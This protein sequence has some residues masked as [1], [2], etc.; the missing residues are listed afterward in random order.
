MKRSNGNPALKISR[1]LIQIL[2]F[3]FLPALYFQAFSGVKQL[4]L[5][6][7]HWQFQWSLWPQVAE[8]AMILPVTF[9]LGRFFCG[10]MCAFGSFTDWIYHLFQKIFHKKLKISETWDRRMK[11]LKYAVLL[12]IL[13]ASW[14]LNAPLFASSSPW[15]AFGMLITVGKVPDFAYVLSSLTVGFLLF[16]LITA[17]S[18]FSERFFC[19][20]LCP[21]GAIFSLVSRR[22]L[23]KI[24]KPSAHCGSCRAC[25]KN[26]PMG[27]PLYQMDTVDSG[28]CIGCMKCVSVCPRGNAGLSA[29][30]REIRPLAA[31]ITAAAVLAGTYYTV[32]LSQNLAG[33][34]RSVSA[35]WS[36]SSAAADSGSLAGTAAGSSE[37]QTQPSGQY[38]DGT[39]HGTGTGFRGGKTEVTVVVANGK[40]QSVTADSNEDT[41]SFFNAA[42]PAVSNEIVS[43]QSAEVDAVSGATYSSRGIMEAVADALKSAKA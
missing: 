34:D 19:R 32:D 41:P 8:A 9:L 39:Y 3:I 20:Y 12:V 1:V 24:R 28:E 6:L 31:G 4:Y 10:W 17:V 23:L 14:T 37:S 7:I 38:Q 2:F 29:S 26:C 18:A 21:M 27:I 42:Y 25:T 13:A 43:S 22:K 5:A 36:V 33:G 11:Y 35:G 40:I 15:D 30:G 16:L